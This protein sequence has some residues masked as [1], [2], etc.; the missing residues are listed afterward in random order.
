M[1]HIVWII[2]QSFQTAI[3]QPQNLNQCTAFKAPIAVM[4]NTIFMVVIPIIIGVST[5]PL[6]F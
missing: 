5:I 3:I 2:G 6:F 1:Y 4:Y